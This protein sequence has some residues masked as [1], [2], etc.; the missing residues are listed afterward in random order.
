LAATGAAGLSA[1]LGLGSGAAAS[2]A[3]AVGPGSESQADAVR[4]YGPHQQGIATPTQQYLQFAAL[5]VASDSVDDLRWVL[6][7]LSSGAEHLALGKPVGALQTGGQPPV[8]TGEAI[9]LPP[10]RTTVTIGLGP[11]LFARGRFGLA[12]RRPKPLADLPAFAGD[13]LSRQICGGDVGLQVCADDPQVAFH[14]VH[15]LIRLVASVAP[16]RWLLA[17]FGR[18]PNSRAQTTP[19]NLMGFKDGTNNLMVED[20]GALRRFVWAS[21]PESPR[22]MSGGSYM[23]VRRIAMDLGTW[24]DTGLDQQQLTFGRQKLSGAPLGGV[25][26]HD[27]VNL[28]ARRGGKPLIPLSA[29]IRLASSYNTGQRILRRGDSYVDGLDQGRHSPAAGLLFICYQRDPRKQFVPIQ[30]R[31]AALDALNQFTTHVGS[32][33]FACPPG[34]KRGG[35]VGEGLFA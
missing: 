30:R 15:V 34:V 17:G 21:E 1:G 16:A 28:N 31:L 5:D 11:K 23:V 20:E 33:I 24:D 8:D 10:A 7:Q 22:W 3:R 6:R 18:T 2:E 26:E 13:R 35:F 9:G 29:H 4:F 14:A 27:P 32:A 19:R 25:H 12:S